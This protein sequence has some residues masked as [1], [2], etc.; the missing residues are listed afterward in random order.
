[1]TYNVPVNPL[2]KSAA[3]FA[4][5][6][7]NTVGYTTY[8]SGCLTHALQVNK[9]VCTVWECSFYTKF[10]ILLNTQFVLYK[11][12]GLCDHVEMYFI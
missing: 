7:L 9:S 5:D 6:A 3:S 12:T 2:V 1:M 11:D 8:T 10:L 4:R